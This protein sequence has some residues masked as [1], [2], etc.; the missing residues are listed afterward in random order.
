MGKNKN[1]GAVPPA[2]K[3]ETPAVEEPEVINNQKKVNVI[4][5]NN[6][7]EQFNNPNPGLDANHQVDL[8]NGLD[9]HF[10][11]PNAATKLGISQETVDK[12]NTFTAHGWVIVAANEGMFG[13]SAFAGTVRQSMLPVILD[14]AKDMGINIDQKALPA[15]AA[16]GTIQIP[17]SAIKPS[18]EAAAQ[19]KKEHEALVAKPEIDPTKIETEEDLTKAVNFI[20][21]D[22]ANGYEKLKDSINFYRAYLSF[23]NKDNAEELAK[24]KAKSNL[25][26]L[27]EIREIIKDC[28]LVLSGMG[29]SM[30]TFT[31]STKSPVPAFCMLKN[32]TKNRKTGEFALTDNEVADYTR[33]IVLWANDINIAK[34]NRNIEEHEKNLK[35]LSSDKKANAKAI[36]EV[37]DKIESCK[38]SIAHCNEI[39][40]TVI[41]ANFKAVDTLIENYEAK[42]RI[43]N[44][45]F[46]HII[47]VYYSDVDK[48]KTGMDTLKHN[49]QQTAGIITNL[50]RDPA[51]PNTEYSVANLVEV[52]RVEK[53]GE[54]G[55]K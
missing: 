52:T 30:G 55:K 21:A 12:V 24:V 5:A 38:N 48:E 22:R 40:D 7:A 25:E 44:T 54:E 32:S 10:M 18:K 51:T 4:D 45:I 11:Q 15:P 42:D 36:E 17:S 33:F 1:K 2:P 20:M 6:L 50:F 43:A 49:V 29:R 34:Y 47:M 13:T 27:G 9:R 23:K 35:A 8:L 53:E 31:G 46:N 16:D 37:N 41:N 28:P 3:V 39:A 14:A 26:L 19:L